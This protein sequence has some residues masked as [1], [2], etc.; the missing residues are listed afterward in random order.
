MA[1]MSRVS[2]PKPK[3]KPFDISKRVVW[4]AY[5]KVKANQA[6]GVDEESIA[7]FER[8]LKGNLYKLW[9]RMT[10]TPRPS[11]CR[12][13]AS[14]QARRSRLMGTATSTTSTGTATST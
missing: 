12:P 8:D 6:A 14:A 11:A 3:E 9:N 1:G 7:E 5:R 4:D 13:C 10:S 2:G